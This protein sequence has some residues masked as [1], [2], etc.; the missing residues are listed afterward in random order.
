MAAI[1]LC[2]QLQTSSEMSSIL[3]VVLDAR[4]QS[5][6][7]LASCYPKALLIDILLDLG[8]NIFKLPP[9]FN[10]SLHQLWGRSLASLLENKH[11]CAF[12]TLLWGW[13]ALCLAS[14]LD[15]Q[16]QGPGS[17]F[18]CSTA[19]CCKVTNVPVALVWRVNAVVLVVFPSLK[20]KVWSAE[21][22]FAY[23]H[24]AR[25]SSPFLSALQ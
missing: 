6:D 2:L 1:H 4:W 20:I 3:S 9:S 14:L 19:S 8:G 21:I 11:N 18:T 12:V 13:S 23:A 10:S 25:E 24:R 7:V 16:G 5:G 15:E 22:W 17:H